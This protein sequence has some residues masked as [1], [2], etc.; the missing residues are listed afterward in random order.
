MPDEPTAPG[1]PVTRPL[2]PVLRGPD[3]DIWGRANEAIEAAERHRKRMWAYARD[4]YRREKQRGYADGWNTGIAEASRLVAATAARAERHVDALERELPALVI[5]IVERMLGAFDPGDL[6]SH[7][8]RHALGRL[9]TGA[10]VVLRVAPD[11]A[12]SLRQT[13]GQFDGLSGAKRLCI[14]VDPA[15]KTGACVLCSEFGN[16]ELG[17]AAQVKALREGLEAQAH[18]A[19]GSEAADASPQQHPSGFTVTG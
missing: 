11:E 5:E 1:A 15:I 4:A 14:E 2:G 19:T 10:D 18:G 12:H 13:L 17:I 8:V 16:V 9:R 7:A 6:L 3:V